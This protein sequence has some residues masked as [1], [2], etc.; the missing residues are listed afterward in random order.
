MAANWLAD[1]LKGRLFTRFVKYS[2]IYVYRI[3]I[4][5]LS[6]NF[7]HST[8]MKLSLDELPAYDGWRTA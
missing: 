4:V 6:V 5:Q 3:K 2:R 1:E 8:Q 7:I